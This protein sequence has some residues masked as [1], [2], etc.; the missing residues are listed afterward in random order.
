MNVR[1]LFLSGE[2]ADLMAEPA[3]GPSMTRPDESLTIQEILLNFTRGTLPPVAKT[4]QYADEDYNDYLLN[5]DSYLDDAIN[6][7]S[8]IDDIKSHRTT[9]LDAQLYADRMAKEKSEAESVTETVTP[10][11]SPPNVEDDK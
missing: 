2:Y 9:V 1:E 5:N 7:P 8:Y 3:T 4:P 6:D 11:P 10:P